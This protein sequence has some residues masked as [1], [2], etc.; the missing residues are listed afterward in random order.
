MSCRFQFSLQALMVVMLIVAV[1]CAVWTWLPT[2]IQD[3][4]KYVAVLA[5]LW[6][7]QDPELFGHKP[8]R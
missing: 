8:P 1:G 7:I 5:G 3:A 6:F 4:A 2:P